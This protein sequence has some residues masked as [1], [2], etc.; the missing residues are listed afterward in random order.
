MADF[1]PLS[2]RR[3]TVAT[4]LQNVPGGVPAIDSPVKVANIA[5]V[6]TSNMEDKDN[7]VDSDALEDRASETDEMG[8]GTYEPGG[9]IEFHV[10]EEGSTLDLLTLMLGNPT[11][12]DIAAV[13]EF[14]AY[15]EHL[16][17]NVNSFRW[18]TI[19]EKVLGNHYVR[20]G[21]IL[22]SLNVGVGKTQNKFVKMQA[23]LEALNAINNKSNTAATDTGFGTAAASGTSYFEPVRAILYR[24]GVQWVGAREFN[25]G[26]NAQLA[27]A[28]DLNGYRGMI[29]YVPGVKTVSC[30]VTVFF[31]TEAEHRR[32]L[33]EMDL[34]K[35]VYGATY[36]TVEEDL[37][38]RIPGPIRGTVDD[39]DVFQPRIDFGLY[40]GVIT[41]YNAQK[42]PQQI[43]Q[44]LT[45]KPKHKTSAGTDSYCRVK[46]LIPATYYTTVRTALANVPAN[47]G[48]AYTNP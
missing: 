11:V 31:S 36:T 45:I 20:W 12:T 5:K 40:R 39:E 42:G 35:N 6:A 32:F 34:T 4:S 26:W 2:G 1:V 38:L 3:T 37:E 21:A 16:F 15:H 33:G 25:F 17:K 9:A 23:Q 8:V 44:R 29:P 22:G 41:V 48:S 13:D 27:R 24:A 14:L 28:D 7:K 30:D 43:E 18:G 19:L 46:N 10:Q 47:A